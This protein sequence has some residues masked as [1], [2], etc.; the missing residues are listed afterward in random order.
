MRINWEVFHITVHSQL[1]GH[2]E[3]TH[4]KKSFCAIH[5][6]RP[7]HD[8]IT[9]PTDHCTYM[10]KEGI[11]FHVPYVVSFFDFGH[12]RIMFRVCSYAVVQECVI[13]HV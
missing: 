1:L 8:Q 2:K 10:C 7:F 9:T 11:E 3:N 13:V 6:Y 5:P 4:N 12:Y